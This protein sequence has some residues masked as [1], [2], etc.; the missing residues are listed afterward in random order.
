MLKDYNLTKCYARSCNY[1]VF[2]R[3]VIANG[4]KPFERPNHCQLSK[5]DW[6][7]PLVTT[8]SFRRFPP[9]EWVTCTQSAT[10]AMSPN[11]D[12][13]T[14]LDIDCIW[15]Y[16]HWPARCF[17]LRQVISNQEVDRQVSSQANEF[18][19]VWF[20]SSD[21]EHVHHLE[22]RWHG[23]TSNTNLLLLTV[24]LSPK[25]ALY[26]CRRYDIAPFSTSVLCGHIMLY[27]IK[28]G[29]QKKRAIVL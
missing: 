21:M 12:V 2:L 8:Q 9:R 24:R 26:C 4:T 10:G 5:F 23:E 15:L 1:S 11:M 3:N 14:C 27:T 22:L 13:L 29:C 17:F 18:Y 16:I 25:H 6:A 19:L 7:S 20:I 28:L